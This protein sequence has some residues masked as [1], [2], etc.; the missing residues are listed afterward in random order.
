MQKSEYFTAVMMERW[1][2]SCTK[3]LAM[4]QQEVKVC[5]KQM[6]QTKERYLA[7]FKYIDYSGITDIVDVVACW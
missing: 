6:I 5:A 7:E 2:D 1:N 4:E 3:I